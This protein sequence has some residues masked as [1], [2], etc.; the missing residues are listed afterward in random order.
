[1]GLQQA[2][3]L[4]VETGISADMTRPKLFNPTTQYGALIHPRAIPQ[5]LLERLDSLTRSCF[6]F[7][8]EE[9]W[10]DS[11]ELEEWYEIARPR[12]SLQ[13]VLAELIRMQ[14]IF[15]PENTG[16]SAVMD[17]GML[18]TY[19]ESMVEQSGNAG[20]YKIMLD[21]NP[22]VYKTLFFEKNH[23]S[24][25]L[26]YCVSGDRV[27][28]GSGEVDDEQGLSQP[29]VRY[30]EA[31]QET[32]GLV[33]HREILLDLVKDGF[34]T[35]V[36]LVGVPY[37]FLRGTVKPD[38][39]VVPVMKVPTFRGLVGDAVTYCDELRSGVKSN[40]EIDFPDGDFF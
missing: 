29:G 37:R 19:L 3:A 38:F 8:G 24:T 21:E 7:M 32:R 25:Q 22:L 18:L 6:E 40:D 4:W 27:L 14:L 12:Q 15:R 20:I 34:D 30:L 16:I 28:Y 26:A 9:C 33:P 23:G 36:R 1:M 17:V 31:G 13:F 35:Q 5:A 39:L 11:Q 10:K 2:R